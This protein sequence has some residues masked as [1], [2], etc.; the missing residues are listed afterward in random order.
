MAEGHWFGETG[1]RGRRVGE[2]DTLGGRSVGEAKGLGREKACEGHGRVVVGDRYGE[3]YKFGREMGCWKGMGLREIGW[4]VA[5]VRER[6]AMGCRWAGEAEKLG[7]DMNWGGRWVGR[8]KW[9]GE[10]ERFGGWRWAGDGDGLKRK[11]SLGKEM[12][13]GD[14]RVWCGRWAVERERLGREKAWEGHGLG[15]MGWA[16]EMCMRMEMGCWKGMGFWWR[17]VGKGEA[18]GREMHWAGD[19]L[20]R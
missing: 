7:K 19:G 2:R 3:G 18:L 8:G 6:D 14:R 17:L 20:G 4:A 10:G 1:W 9:V 12:G 5:W 11:M 15:K 13:C 16:R